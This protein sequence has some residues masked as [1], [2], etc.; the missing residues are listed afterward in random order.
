[1]TLEQMINDT[2]EK[3]PK[4]YREK[5]KGLGFPLRRFIAALVEGGLYELNKETTNILDL[6][7]PEKCPDEWF[8]YL[9]R[10]FGLEYFQ[11]IDISYQRR[12]LANIGEIIRRR[13]TYAC[14]RYMVSVLT[15]CDVELSYLRGTYKGQKGRHLIVSVLARTI[16]EIT[17]MDV[18]VKVI[19]RYLEGHIPFYISP[20]IESRIAA[21]QVKSMIYRRNAITKTVYYNLGR[22]I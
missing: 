8:P 2:Y 6:V 7:D 17:G 1:M 11:D 18:N 14:V 10:S 13:G 16:E 9:C 5:D 19:E 15:G 3:L 22:G 20:H 21:Q 12:F 4:I